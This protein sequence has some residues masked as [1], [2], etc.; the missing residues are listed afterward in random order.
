MFAAWK[1]IAEEVKHAN[2]SYMPAVTSAVLDKRIPFH[3]D[4]VL[5]KWYSELKGK[6]RWRVLSHRLDQS[7]ACIQ[8]FDAL[9][10]I[11]RAGEAAR[12]SGVELS[13]SFPGI[14]G[15][16]Y[17]VE[18]VLLRALQ[19]LRSDERGSRRGLRVKA[20]TQG[21]SETTSSR[22]PNLSA[23]TKSQSQS[24]WKL[25]RTKVE[26]ENDSDGFA[27]DDRQYFFYSPSL[28]D[29][30]RQE[31]LEVQALTLEP[32]SGH[33]QDPVV[34][35]DFTALYPSLVIAYNL[36]YS[37][38]AGK[39]DYHSTRNEMRQAGKT[40]GR[41]GPF[42]YIEGRTATVLTH[43]MRSIHEGAKG[44]ASKPET[45]DDRVYIAPTGT[46]YASEDVVKGVLPQVLDEILTTRAMLKKAAKEYKKNVPNL[47]PAILRQLEA[48]QLALKYVANVTYGYTSATFSGR[49][50]MPLLAD[51]IVECGRKTLR[52]A[53]DMVNKWG[54]E[55]PKWKGCKVIYGD[56]DSLFIKLPGRSYKEAFEFGEYVCKR[57]T[58]DNP[59]P[60]QL[61]LEKVYVG[62]IMQ[63]VSCP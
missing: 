46:L 55:H 40:T 58:A 57:V 20:K 11:G 35:C 41:L 21:S 31:A 12:L 26:S 42:R 22:S 56:T 50:A 13:Q 51:T 43:H 2:A 17:K 32:L 3:D 47:S 29:T 48:R 54:R 59:P 38:C 15:S 33:Y 53:I 62:S 10:I 45:N 27:S 24:P 8:L 7:V 39:L 19:S 36:C 9:D 23:R 14:R 18:G 1:I 30:N 44:E 28:S 37:T 34:V 25:R 4:M 60:V 63:T 61:K 5:T 49:C 6:E 52:K 16:Q